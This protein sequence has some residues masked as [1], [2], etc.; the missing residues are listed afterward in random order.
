MGSLDRAYSEAAARILTAARADGR[1]WDRLT[2]MTDTFGHRLSGS[3][4]LEAAIRWT[5]EQMRTDGL[6]NVRLEPVKVPH[7]VRG[8]ESVELV[9]PFPG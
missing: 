2:E 4:A 8:R 5:A 9:L 3:E 1:A 7:W 6:E